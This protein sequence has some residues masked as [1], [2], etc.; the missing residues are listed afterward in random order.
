MAE[1]MGRH[2]LDRGV[3]QVGVR[4]SSAVSACA[5]LRIE[6]TS[7]QRPPMYASASGAALIAGCGWTAVSRGI[8]ATLAYCTTGQTPRSQRF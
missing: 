3:L 2:Q 8:W 5:V 4:P 7:L 6:N 1:L